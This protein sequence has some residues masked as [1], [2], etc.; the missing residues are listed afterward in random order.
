MLRLSLSYINSMLPK[1]KI[2]YLSSLKIKKY[3]NNANKFII[4]GTR[5]VEEAIESIMHFANINNSKN[6][7]DYLI[8]EILITPDYENDRS[9]KQII[10]NIKKNNLILDIISNDEMKK[11]ASSKTCQGIIALI[12]F[13]YSKNKIYDSPILFLD[14]ISNPGNL[15][16]ILRSADW[17]GIKTVYL[18]NNSVDPYNPKVIQ[19][20]MGAIFYIQSIIQTNI[21]NELIKYKKNG[22]TVIGSSLNGVSINNIK[23]DNK[24]ILL[25]GNEARGITNKLE[26]YIDHNI[27]INKFGNIE[28]LN[29][30]MAGSIILSKLINETE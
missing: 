14:D 13:K 22:Y 10:K 20:S 2:K 18:S 8:E 30:A 29:V 6:P 7:S 4:E 9:N 15:G 27:T 23:I 21:T 5:L 16:T 24:W 25:L 11:I 26:K 19:S 28:S 17:F 1:E 3:R 12:N